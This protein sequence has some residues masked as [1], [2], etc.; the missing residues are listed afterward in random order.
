MDNSNEVTIRVHYMRPGVTGK[1]S[2]FIS[3]RCKPNDIPTDVESRTICSVSESSGAS[4]EEIEIQ[5]IEYR[6]R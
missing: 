3:F 4:P 2:D 6:E 1:I 5:D